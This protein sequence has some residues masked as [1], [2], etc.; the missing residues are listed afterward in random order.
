MFA[1]IRPDLDQAYSVMTI[2]SNYWSTFVAKAK[3][4]T[5]QVRKKTIKQTLSLNTAYFISKLTVN[6]IV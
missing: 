2:K 4:K 1:E 6:E 3:K 5:L